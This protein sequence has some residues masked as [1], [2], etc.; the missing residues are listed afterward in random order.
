MPILDKTIGPHFTGV[1]N[2]YRLITI[3]LL[4]PYQYHTQQLS[5]DFHYKAFFNHCGWIPAPPPSTQQTT[6]AFLPHPLAFFSNLAINL[7]CQF[8]PPIES[9]CDITIT[10]ILL[11]FFI[12]LS[13]GSAAELSAQTYPPICSTQHNRPQATTTTTTTTTDNKNDKPRISHPLKPSCCPT[14]EVGL[15]P[16]DPQSTTQVWLPFSWHKQSHD[17]VNATHNATHSRSRQPSAPS[18]IPP[19]LHS[20]HLYPPLKSSSATVT[21]HPAR[22][23]VSSHTIGLLEH[24]DRFFSTCLDLSDD[25]N[26]HVDHQE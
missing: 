20:Y 14:F 23:V 1:K 15:Q 5:E 18:P 19:S 8:I 10:I 26:P 3:P 21:H 25:I 9:A 24:W 7:F 13:I 11:S 2:T 16:L 17:I 6:D 22:S 4:A 12:N